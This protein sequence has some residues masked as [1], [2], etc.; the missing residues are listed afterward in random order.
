MKRIEKKGKPPP[1][2]PLGANANKGA[3]P[4]RILVPVVVNT[5]IREYDA[6]DLYN[7]A[8]DLDDVADDSTPERRN[9]ETDD[10]RV[11]DLHGAFINPDIVA[12]YCSKLS[13]CG[14]M[15]AIGSVVDAY[16]KECFV[17]DG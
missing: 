11:L 8:A 7:W 12:I 14:N 6:M 15:A 17:S 10:N 5:L 13:D 16:L 9:Q 3:V 1:S 4:P 2:S